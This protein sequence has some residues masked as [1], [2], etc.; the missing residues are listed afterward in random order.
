MSLIYTGSDWNVDTIE[1]LYHEC[2]IIGKDELRLDW[3][4]NQFEIVNYEQMLDVYASHGM[5]IMYNHWSFGK[6][7]ITNVV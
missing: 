5:P 1:K 7:C 3:Y 6:S 4:K 2:S